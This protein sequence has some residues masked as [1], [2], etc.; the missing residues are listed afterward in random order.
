MLEQEHELLVQDTRHNVTSESISISQYTLLN[1]PD[2]TRHRVASDNVV[3]IQSHTLNIQD[4]RHKVS[5]D[6]ILKIINWDEL[7]VYFGIY[8]PN[9]KQPGGLQPVYIDEDLIYKAISKPGGILTSADIEDEG[10]LKPGNKE[11]G[12]L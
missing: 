10:I 4:A 11:T 12:I 1:T 2:S 8:K 6:S 3:L 9:S 5:S 7:G